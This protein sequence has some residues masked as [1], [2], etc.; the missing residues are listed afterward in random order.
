[1]IAAA[2][3]P[4]DPVGTIDTPALVIDLD[5]LDRNIERMAAFARQHRLLLRPHAK[6]HKSAAIARLQIAAGAVGVCVQKLSEAQALV[7]AGVESIFIS[8]EIVS[9]RKLVQLVTLA[10]RARLSIAVDSALGIE[11]LAQVLRGTQADIGVFVEVDVGQGR[12]GV[13]PAQAGALA[14]QVVSHG[15]RF[16]GLQAYQGGA[17]HL[18]TASAREAA[19]RHSQSLARAA[20]ASVTADGVACPLVTGAGTGTFVFEAGD[21]ADRL[22]GEVQPGSYVFMD[23]DYGLNEA[24]PGAPVFEQSLFVKTSVI[25]VGSAHAVVDAGHKSHAIDSGLPVVWQS[26]FE[27]RNGGDEHGIL[28]RHADALPALGDALWLVPGHCDP[29]VNLH[30]HYV[31]V[32]GGLQSGTVEAIWPVDGRGCIR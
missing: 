8:N 28:I 14:R 23:R 7:D 24:M 21:G 22:Y 15:R 26:D 16:A 10:T 17:Q 11:R 6:T 19:T 12:C 25:S 1:M 2:A 31:G 13:P 29:T 9:A 30:D 18:R 20:L 4:G 32:R 5:A 3:S 27:F